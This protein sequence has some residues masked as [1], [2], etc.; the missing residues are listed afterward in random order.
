MI[1]RYHLIAKIGLIHLVVANFCTWFEGK[2]LILFK[3][4][5]IKYFSFSYCIRNIGTTV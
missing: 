3:I 4:S 1:N 5:V 2:N